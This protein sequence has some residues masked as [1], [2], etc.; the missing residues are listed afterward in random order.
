VR[1]AAVIL[2]VLVA[3]CAAGRIGSPAA[4]R[5]S[6]MQADRE[7]AAATAENGMEGWMQ[8]YTAD[9]VRLQLGGEVAQGHAAIREFD[10][11]IFQD[12][13][14]RLTWEPTDGGVFSDGRHGFTTGRG[15]LVRLTPPTDTLWRGSYVT[16]WRLEGGRW[17]VILDT[18]ASD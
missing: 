13:M 1:P 14:I 4:G 16:L 3:G 15:A 2:A 8:A 11:G 9:A 17:K 10:A 5:E 6:L 18:G 12:P 7:F